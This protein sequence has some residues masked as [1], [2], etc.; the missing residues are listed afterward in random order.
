MRWKKKKGTRTVQ[1]RSKCAPKKPVVANLVE[2]SLLSLSAKS[3]MVRF[4]FAL[5]L[6]TAIY[7]VGNIGNFW[8]IYIGPQKVD[9]FF[10]AKITLQIFL[11]VKKCYRQSDQKWTF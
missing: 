1:L 4:V 9:F 8:L 6:R 7:T 10:G 2:L 3:L 5:L 11:R